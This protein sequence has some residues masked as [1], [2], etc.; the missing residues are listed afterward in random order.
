MPDNGPFGKLGRSVFR[1]SAAHQRQRVHDLLV[2]MERC[3]GSSCPTTA[4]IS[5]LM[6][7][8]SEKN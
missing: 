7:L 2:D 5:A 4:S 8:G 1:S 6:L 3:H